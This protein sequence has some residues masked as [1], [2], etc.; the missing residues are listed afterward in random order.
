MPF[1][2]TAGSRASAASRSGIAA[3]QRAAARRGLE[4]PSTDRRPAAPKPKCRLRNKCTR[5]RCGR[6][7]PHGLTSGAR[8][9]RPRDVNPHGG[10]GR[11][12]EW[13]FVFVFRPGPAIQRAP[14]CLCRLPQGAC[15][16]GACRRAAAGHGP[17]LRTSRSSTFAACS[18]IREVLD[19]ATL[20]VTVVGGITLFG[21]ML[22]LLGAVA[23]TKF[24]RLYEA[25]LPDARRQHAPDRV[26]DR[27]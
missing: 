9:R 5:G 23:V 7:R 12:P 15:G 24:Q 16:P 18:S 4:Q 27:H 10:V 22:I 11:G 6:Q 20:G 14:P 19:N 21:G 13:R 25:D 1:A 26:D 17:R 3:G 2:S 8:D